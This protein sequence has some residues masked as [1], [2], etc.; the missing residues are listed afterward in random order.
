MRYDVT[1]IKKGL[2]KP[3]KKKGD[4][5]AALGRAPSAVSSL[6]KG[7]REIKAHE[8]AIIADYLEVQPPG[9]ASHSATLS[10]TSTVA[11]VSGNRMQVVMAGIVEAGAFREFDDANQDEPETITTDADPRWPKARHFAVRVAG[12]S[13]NACQPIPILDGAIVVCVDYSDIASSYPLRDGMKVVIQRVRDGGHLREWSIK[14]IEVQDDRYIFHPRSTSTRHKPIIVTTDLEADD[15]TTVSVLG[16][17][18]R[19]DN[20]EAD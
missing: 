10:P 13:M 15:G 20:P 18:R 17:V 8:I 7:D 11:P 14:Q 1:W 19:I 12:D 5:A 16:W 2:E 9:P 6:L 3:G 4:L